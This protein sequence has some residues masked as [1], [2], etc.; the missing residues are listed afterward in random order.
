M[1]HWKRGGS[2]F[3]LGC[4]VSLLSL[5]GAY[6]KNH[7]YQEQYTQPTFICLPIRARLTWDIRRRACHVGNWQV[8][9]C[10]LI[11]IKMKVVILVSYLNMLLMKGKHVFS[12]V[13]KMMKHLEVTFGGNQERHEVDSDCAF[14]WCEDGRFTISSDG[15]VL[16]AW[17]LIHCGSLLWSYFCLSGCTAVKMAWNSYEYRKICKGWQPCCMWLFKQQRLNTKHM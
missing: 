17:T 7:L 9:V 5:W 6:Q 1:L 8:V 11:L 2:I 10:G 14:F 15:F 12:M 16:T 3:S 4:M 13:C